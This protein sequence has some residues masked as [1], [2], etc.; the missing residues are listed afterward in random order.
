MNKWIYLLAIALSLTSCIGTDVLEEEIFPE[1]VQIVSSAD[2]IKVG[3]SFQ[4][5]ALFFNT[6][7]EMEDVALNWRSLDNSIIEINQNGL[8]TAVN[9]GTTQLI[10]EAN[11][12]SD[13]ALVT[14]GAVTVSSTN[15]DARTGTF[16]GLN[17]YRVEGSFKM[18]LLGES[19][20]RLSFE[21]DFVASNG[22]G[23]FIYLTN[24]ENSIS[25]GIELGELKETRGAQFYDF[26]QA[27]L[28][29]VYSYVMVYCKP[30][31]VPFG[32]GAFEN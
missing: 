26:D 6:S 10:V 9:G 31:G 5:I 29:N 15:T 7:G 1:R 30:F 11:A 2:T 21:D 32:R 25:G 19:S 14:A 16:Q 3:E 24:N 28:F 13:T 8:A 17:N 23:L 18:E 27:D 4:F 20:V 12:V 22:P